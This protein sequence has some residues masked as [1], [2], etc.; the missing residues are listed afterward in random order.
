MALFTARLAGAGE[1]RT[2]MI[3]TDCNEQ[4]VLVGPGGQIAGLIDWG[5]CCESALVAEVAIAMAYAALLEEEDPFAAAGPLL[6]GYE[7]VLPLTPPE[8]GLLRTLCMGRLAQSLSLGYVAAEQHPENREYLLGTQRRGWDVLR[9][10]WGL[11]DEEFLARCDGRT[12][13][14]ND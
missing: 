11:S 2:Q 9:L 14:L 8:R 10:L 3:H 13:C 1:L 12:A 5:D 6:R 7:S 4:N